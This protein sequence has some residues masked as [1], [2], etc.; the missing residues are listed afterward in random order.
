MPQPALLIEELGQHRP[1]PSAAGPGA[2]PSAEVVDRLCPLLDLGGDLPV[3]DGPAVADVH[4]LPAAVVVAGVADHERDPAGGQLTGQAERD[5]DPGR[6]PPADPD[7][8]GRGHAT[9]DR[10]PEPADMVEAGSLTGERWLA[11]AILSLRKV[12]GLVLGI[13]KPRQKGPWC[14]GAEWSN[15]RGGRATS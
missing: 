12:Y 6:L 2:A 3:A 1:A 13:P 15:R 5:R 4:R 9:A 10:D 8:L 14:K 7:S 11:H